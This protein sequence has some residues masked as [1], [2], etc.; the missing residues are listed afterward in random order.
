M[1]GSKQKIVVFST[2]LLLMGGILAGFVG[3]AVLVDRQAVRKHEQ[4]FQDHQA[5]QTLLAKQA[6]EDHIQGFFT[7]TRMMASYD[8]PEFAQGKRDFSSLQH[9][10][11]FAQTVY[12]GALTYLY[13]DAA[14]HIV[15]ADSDSTPPGK[16][17][18]EMTRKWVNA[19]WYKLSKLQDEYI[20]PPFFVTSDY[21]ML[22]FLFPVLVNAKFVGV[23]AA[24]TDLQPILLRYVAT[25][26][27]GEYG[28]GYVLDGQGNVVYDHETFVIGR[29]VFDGLHAQYPDVMRLDRR[30]MHESSGMDEYTFTIKRGGPISRKLIAWHTLFLGY[31][32]LVICLSAPDIE[33]DE[34]LSDL[35]FQ[36][37]I[38]GG[39]LAAAYVLVSLIIFRVRQQVLRRNTQELQQRVDRRT[40]ELATSEARYRTLFESANDT[41]WL[42]AQ[43]RVVDCNA[44]TLELFHCAQEEIIGSTPYD[45]SPPTQPDGRDSREAALEKLEEAFQGQPQFFEWQH[46]RCDGSVFD[47]EVNLNRV[48]LAGSYFIMAIVRD[49][50]ERKQVEVKIRQLNET[51]ERRVAERTQELEEANS[52]LRQSIEQ[53][54]Q[55]QSQLIQAEKMAALGGLVAGVAHEINTPLG[56]GVTAASYLEFQT[57]EL[58]S[59]Y[60]ANTMTRTELERYLKTAEESSD[61]LLSN[62]QRA[63]KLIRSF[64]QVAVDQSLEEKRRIRLKAYL[65]DIFLSLQPALKKTQ[66]V[67]SIECPETLEISTY[68][69]ALSQIMT[70]LVMNSLIHAFEDRDRGEIRIHIVLKEEEIMSFIYQDNGKGIPEEHI[71]KVFDPFFTTK[72]SEGGSGLGLHIVYNLVTQKLKGSITCQSHPGEGATFTITLPLRLQG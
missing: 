39:F 62:L 7:G 31:Q 63:A 12:S 33:I 24:V 27:S 17:A 13:C 40:A 42:M 18:F 5:L 21:Q 6:L 20:V 30:L 15:H 47:A 50:T 10:F 45:L 68:P 3:M 70:N 34:T 46:L 56:V 58:L 44:R 29:N 53:L 65:D 37:L 67:L 22:G 11:Q 64:K 25:M 61:I 35:R 28:A 60:H 48:E 4:M 2:S 26:R 55:T 69:G 23:L 8:L 1:S 52:A 49:I 9:L 43:D 71:P 72:R 14:S 66:H 38:S 16:E 41:I 51:L 54:M 32:R 59:R 36:W 19:Y 57:Q